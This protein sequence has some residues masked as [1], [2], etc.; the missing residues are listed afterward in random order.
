M[1]ASPAPALATEALRLG[2]TPR[3]AEVLRLLARRLTDRE[4]AETLFISTKTAGKHV[5]NILAK[6]PAAD[7]RQAA[8]L[9]EQ[10]GLT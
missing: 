7:R 4:I 2:L 1:N 6:L 3:E 10:L 8:A 5:S 9:A